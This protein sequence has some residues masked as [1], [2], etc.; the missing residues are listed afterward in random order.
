MTTL[1]VTAAP[2]QIVAN[3]A[4]V[5][6]FCFVNV[7]AAG[8]IRPYTYGKNITFAPLPLNVCAHHI[9]IQC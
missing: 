3:V 2:M 1:T 5:T 9:Y 4:I 8:V 7:E 6:F